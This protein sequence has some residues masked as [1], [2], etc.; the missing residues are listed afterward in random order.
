MLAN[1]SM[2]LPS[3]AQGKN[4]LSKAS[5]IELGRLRTELETRK[6]LE[7]EKPITLHDT[8]VTLSITTMRNKELEKEN[9]RLDNMLKL[10][11]EHIKELEQALQVTKERNDVL[12][13][14]F[15]ERNEK[16]ALEMTE[17][18]VV[19]AKQNTEY[20]D[21][22]EELVMAEIERVQCSA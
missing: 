21:P 11:D 14:E 2:P 12:E 8:L 16:I 7:E 3:W 9:A 6:K 4:N 18:I 19:D 20:K 5:K 1:Q 15:A 17:V 22:F 13:R 10:A